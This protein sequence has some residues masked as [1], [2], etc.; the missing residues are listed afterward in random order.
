MS[1]LRKKGDRTGFTSLPAA[2]KHPPVD[3]GAKE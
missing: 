2:G 1:V 3:T